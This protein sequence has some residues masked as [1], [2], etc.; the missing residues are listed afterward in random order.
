MFGNYYAWVQR[1]PFKIFTWFFIINKLLCHFIG[2]LSNNKILHSLGQKQL[3][4]LVML[5]GLQ[6]HTN[7]ITCLHLFY[8]WN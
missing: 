1:D 5:L 7:N 3:K 2:I 8:L 6:V 4:V